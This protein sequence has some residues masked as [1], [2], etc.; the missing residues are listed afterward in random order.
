MEFTITCAALQ[1]PLA[2]IQQQINGPHQQWGDRKNYLPSSD[3]SDHRRSPGGPREEL[4]AMCPLAD[5]IQ[6]GEGGRWRLTAVI[7]WGTFVFFCL[8]KGIL[9]DMEHLLQARLPL[10]EL[11]HSAY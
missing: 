9:T 4:G 11:T 1:E 3:S 8:E 6:A 10:C 7:A 5:G 2:G